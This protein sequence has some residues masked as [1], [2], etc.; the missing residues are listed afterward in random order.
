MQTVQGLL[1][2]LTKGELTAHVQTLGLTD[3][4]S[5]LGSLNSRYSSLLDA[6]TNSQIVNAV[7]AAKPI[8]LEMDGLYDEMITTAWAFSIATPSEDLTNFVVFVNKLID[9]TNTAYNQRIAQSKKKEEE[10][11]E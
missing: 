10:T 6:R 3:E 8:R 11:T 9:D 4:V 7:E 2:D 1:N 5:E